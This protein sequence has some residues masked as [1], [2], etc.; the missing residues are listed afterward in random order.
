M[1][2][3]IWQPENIF[4]S[5]YS[6]IGIIPSGS[7]DLQVLNEFIA[8]ATLFELSFRHLPNLLWG[9]ATV[10]CFDILMSPQ[11]R[12]ETT[13]FIRTILFYVVPKVYNFMTIFCRRLLKI[14]WYTTNT[15][16]NNGE[17]LMRKSNYT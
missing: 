9:T 8:H 1:Y 15:Q 10:V 7:T 14:P 17:Q 12:P 2:P 13:L 11:H 3:L 16:H 6:I 4:T 5:F